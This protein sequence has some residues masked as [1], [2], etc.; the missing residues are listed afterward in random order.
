MMRGVSTNAGDGADPFMLGPVYRRLGE[1]YDR[2]GDRAHAI[3]YDT[4]FADLWKDA[5]PT[6]QPWVTAAR[7]RAQALKSGG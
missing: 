5:D 2:K 3:E 7:G 6:L 1:L 4:R